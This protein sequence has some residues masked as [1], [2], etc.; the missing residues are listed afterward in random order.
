MSALEAEGFVVERVSDTGIPDLIVG[1]PQ[2]RRRLFLIEVKD[3]G[4]K[5][6]PAQK[7]FHRKFAGFPVYVAYSVADALLIAQSQL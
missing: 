7:E 6:K 3:V 5:L 2:P 4:G 1:T